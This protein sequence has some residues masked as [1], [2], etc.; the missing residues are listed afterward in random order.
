MSDHLLWPL[1]NFDTN[2]NDLREFPETVEEALPYIPGWDLDD[3]GGPTRSLFRLY[4]AKGDS[5][6][7]AMIK[8][9]EAYCAA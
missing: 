2:E 1:F 8:S 4:V 6:E 7:D 5:I 9:L 3:S